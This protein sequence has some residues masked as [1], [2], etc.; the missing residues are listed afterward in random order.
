MLSLSHNQDANLSGLQG[1]LSPPELLQLG[2]GA[3]SLPLIL[4]AELSPRE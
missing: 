3:S 4:Q 2:S 1:Y